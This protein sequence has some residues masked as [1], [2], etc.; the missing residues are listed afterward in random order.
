MKLFCRLLLIAACGLVGGARQETG[1]ATLEVFS[2]DTQTAVTVDGTTKFDCIGNALSA[3][4]A[5][6]TVLIHGGIYRERIRLPSGEPG[7]PI[8]VRA[9]PGEEVWLSGGTP[10]HDWQPAGENLWT[11][12]L[13]SRPKKV[14]L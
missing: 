12:I 5:G 3:A 11:A 1:A 6:D 14:L 10:I 4:K 9:A 2:P 13:D 8:V 7:K